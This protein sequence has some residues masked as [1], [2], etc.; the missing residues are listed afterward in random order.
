M[1][2]LGP[3]AGPNTSA[4]TLAP[5]EMRRIRSASRSASQ[6]E[7]R[8]SSTGKTRRTSFADFRMAARNKQTLYSVSAIDGSGE[9]LVSG[10]NAG[11]LH[12]AAR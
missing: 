9:T 8:M 11:I 6:P 12:P 7:R 1:R 3:M 5:G 2:I 10:R 4:V